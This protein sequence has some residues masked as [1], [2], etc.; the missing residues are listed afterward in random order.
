MFPSLPALT[1]TTLWDEYYPT[2]G[3][4]GDLADQPG[5]DFPY[6]NARIEAMNNSLAGKDCVIVYHDGGPVALTM[7]QFK[8]LLA[9]D[10]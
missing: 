10:E 2:I 6:S 1:V 3:I 7:Q 9:I 4:Y 5:M 8:K